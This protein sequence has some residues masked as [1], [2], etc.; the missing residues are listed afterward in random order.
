MLVVV[1]ALC[2]GLGGLMTPGRAAAAAPA[3]KV[4]VFGTDDNGFEGDNTAATLRELGLEVD[5]TSSLPAD[6][7]PYSSLWYIGAYSGIPADAQTAVAA[8]VRAGGSAYLTGERPCCESLNATVQSVLRAT[9]RDQDVTVGGRG[10]IAGPFTFNGAAVDAIASEP[11]LLVDF[12]PDSPGGMD[13][14]GGVSS[15][16]VF[17]SNGQVPV[18]AAW[19]DA[20]MQTGRGRIALLMDIDWL[21]YAARRRIIENIQNFLD[22]GAVCSNDPPHPGFLWTGPTATNSPANCTTLT[23]PSTVS[24]TAGSDAGAV[25]L[26]VDATGVTADCVTSHPNGTTTVRCDLRDATEGATLHVTATDPLGTTMRHYTVRPLNDPRNVPD[27]YSAD[28]K[29]WDWPD[30]DGDG[31]PTYWE[32]NGVWVKGK[33][34]NLPGY[35][36]DPQHK[37]VFLHYDFQSGEELNEGTFDEMRAMFAKAPLGNPDGEDG[38]DLHVERGG[39][40]PAS[41]VGDFDLKAAKIQQVA[42]YSGFLNSAQA[43]GGGVPQLFKWM[44][45]FNHSSD[46]GTIGKAFIKGNAGWT[47]FPV[48]SWAAAL[49]INTVPG[50]GAVDFA[51][52]SNSAHELGH[53]LGLDHHGAKATPEYDPKYKSIMSYSYS[54]YGLPSG[55]GHPKH[56]IDYSD[57]SDVNL[58]WEMGKALGKLTFVPGQ[59][60]ELPG[61]YAASNIEQIDD[62]GPTS[63]EP[64][65]EQAALAADPTSVTGFI[66]AFGVDATPSIPTLDD[67][68]AT[69]HVGDT[70]R[71]ALHGRDPGGAAITYVVDDEPVLGT[72][73]VDGGG[74]VYAAATVGEE[75]LHVRALNAKLGSGQAL[76]TIHILPAVSVEV[77]SSPPGGE[78]A[79]PVASAPQPP[80][81]VSGAGAGSRL[82]ALSR[83]MVKRLAGRAGPWARLARVT[84]V[85]AGAEKLAIRI[86]RGPLRACRRA[87]RSCPALRTLQMR[88]VAVRDGASAIVLSLRGARIPAGR[89]RIE[90]TPIGAAGKRGKTITRVLVVRPR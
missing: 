52:A 36:A 9:L 57:S 7:S 41:V 56:H 18:G 44:L 71:I 34:L 6:L 17:A 79:G 55:F 73:T 12:V 89:Y 3:G 84:V 23:T 87:K 67:A 25:D 76:V 13:G 50:A 1:V 60:G 72:A 38:V 10:D 68:E 48:N 22:H 54:N 59:W 33:Y 85:T 53:L 2:V 31:I 81:F 30:Q 77:P 40:V 21:G 75:R 47:A 35:G 45:N 42:T 26:E 28:S 90:L 27:G 16:N 61:F 8:Y 74:L 14:L 4:L 5:R 43:G 46:S 65:A 11:N 62:A 64:T 49:G 20:D 83:A 39:S 78:P 37:D 63:Q 88:T 58:D 24:W 70:A 19:T 15:A 80:S 29:W 69:V 86:R 82:P 51:E 66:D 32:Q